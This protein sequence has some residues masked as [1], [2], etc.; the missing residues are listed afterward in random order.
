MDYFLGGKKMIGTPEAQKLLKF[1][2]E[3]YGQKIKVMNNSI[4]YSLKNKVTKTNSKLLRMFDKLKAAHPVEKMKK[5][6]HKKME[7]SPDYIKLV[8]HLNSGESKLLF[9]NFFHA[10]ETREF[11]SVANEHDYPII[12]HFKYCAFKVGLL[13][14]PNESVKVFK[15]FSKTNKIYGFQNFIFNRPS[16]ALDNL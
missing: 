15:I 9:R 1:L 2:S 14:N 5:L 4:S 12:E 13:F 10:P 16:C 6:F 7:T 8:T 3:S 11:I